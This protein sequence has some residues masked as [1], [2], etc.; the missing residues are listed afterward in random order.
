MTRGRRVGAWLLFIAALALAIQGQRYFFTRPDLAW[1]GLVLHALGAAC[2]L[3]AW[4][5]A[6]PAQGRAIRQP[7]RFSLPAWPAQWPMPAALLAVGSLLALLAGLLA[8]DR[9]LDQPSG[10]V[11]LLWAMGTAAAA[12]AA[13]WPA[14]LPTGRARLALPEGLD[15]AAW[16]E[17]AT[18]ATLTLLALL[19]RTAA[20]AQVPFTLGGDEA[21]HGLLARQVLSGQLR[22][23]FAMGYMSMPTLFYW[24]LSWSLRLAGNDVTALRLPAALAGTATVPVL[25]FFARGLW[26][27]RVALLSAAFLA[28][29]DYQVHYSRLGANN[30]WD[31]LFV[32]LALWALDRGLG[33]HGQSHRQGRG[34]RGGALWLQV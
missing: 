13:L 21:W 19:V 20:L 1:D 2:F 27:R 3:A 34:S 16:L 18:V 25:Y 6:R 29:Y 31:A 17:T 5:L 28:T 15:R 33:P 7:W 12:L 9:L 11:I 30:I 32:L 4:R 14:S 8:R 10:D 22:N 24:P 23:P 26:G